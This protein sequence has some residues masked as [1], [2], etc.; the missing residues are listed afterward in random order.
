MGPGL[1]NPHLNVGIGPST[2]VDLLL[3]SI[4]NIRNS[5]VIILLGVTFFVHYDSEILINEI[6]FQIDGS[7]GKIVG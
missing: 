4:E 5:T 3:D 7:E 2:Q 1:C 6:H